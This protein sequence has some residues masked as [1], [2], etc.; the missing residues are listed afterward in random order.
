[1][2]SAVSAAR[3]FPHSSGEVGP[4]GVDITADFS[5]P[6]SGLTAGAPTP[7][8]PDAI[9][10]AGRAYLMDTASGKF[11]REGIQVVQQ[12]NTSN[13]R[14][15]LLLPQDVW[16]IMQESWHQG[17]GQDNQD[18]NDALPWRFQDS[19]GVDPW[20]R[21]QIS[22]LPAT[23][24]LTGSPTGDH[25]IFLQVHNDV[26]VAGNGTNLYW[27][28]DY[29]S[30]QT[31][32]VASV[33]MI[34]MTYDGQEIIPLFSDGS[35]FY[36]I[37]AS[38]S[39]LHGIYSGASFIA[40]VKD[41]LIAGV[42]NVLK[43]ITAVGTGT[44]IYINPVSGFRWVDACEGPNAIYCIGG[45]GDRTVIHRVGVKQ[46]GTG[47]DTAVVAAQLPDGETGYSIGS[48]LGFLF[49]GTDKGVRMAVP[50]SN[51][52][53]V[54]GALIPTTVPVYGFEG[55]ENFV[56]YTNSA[57]NSAYSGI[58]SDL[59][60]TG[61][62]C[63]LGRMDLTTFTVTEATPAYADDVVAV[64]QSSKTVTSVTTWN[65]KRV[66]GVR[67]GGVYGEIDDL[68]EAGWL[69]QGTISFSVE[70]VKTGFYMQGKWQPLAGSIAFDLSYDST[71]YIRISTYSEPDTIRS[72]N[73]SLN[74]TQFSRI[75]PRYVLI[76]DDEDE[77]AGPVLTRWEV[78]CSPVVGSASRWSLPILNYENIDI[79]GIEDGRD[80]LA[81]FN[82][83][84]GLVRSGEMVS[85][86]ES[87]QSY[88]VIAKNFTWMPSSLT[89]QGTSWQG[90]F[91][92]I[93]EEVA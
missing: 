77:T 58:S 56:W 47:L 65:G 26:L 9:V 55:Q 45:I 70:D 5:E 12:R 81:E 21:W 35:V 61:P 84:I 76:R 88:Q 90:T 48:Y 50:Q 4:I 79:N 59:F 85:L 15:L 8:R 2:P 38:S 49:V 29:T 86:Q 40:Y 52:D 62:V 19:F 82:L 32:T 3:G 63:G 91:V 60:P 43:N 74:G 23:E 83:L 78:R 39:A 34:D 36:N 80:P 33:S 53:L 17:A 51:G 31:Q 67:T 10:L 25:P 66:F 30:S 46:D 93:V 73:I 7:A 87:G 13:E 37:T 14:D 89:Q 22:L 16:R 20:T 1:M 71:G 6:F 92:L 41:Y 72:D 75:E 28:T 44:T 11:G 42:G 64:D 68:M 18:R 69:T 24:K 27:Y 57:V 54:L